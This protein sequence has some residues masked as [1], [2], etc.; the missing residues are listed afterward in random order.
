MLRRK[1]AQLLFEYKNAFFPSPSPSLGFSFQWEPIPYFNNKI[2]CDLV[3]EKHKG[4]ISILVRKETWASFG[5]R[6]R[7]KHVS[8]G[9]MRETALGGFDALPPPPLLES[10]CKSACFFSMFENPLG[11]LE[12]GCV[13]RRSL[14]FP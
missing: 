2:I 10:S 9:W 1:R 14:P 11:A 7:C 13:Q 5:V 3:E 8:C 4:I 6:L 12:V